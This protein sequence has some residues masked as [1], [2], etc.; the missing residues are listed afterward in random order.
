MHNRKTILYVLL[1]VCSSLLPAQEKCVSITIDDLPVAASSSATRQERERITKSLHVALLRHHAP[2]I[3]FVISGKLVRDHGLDSEQVHLLK[4]WIENGF[5]LGNHTFS[6]Q[7]YNSVTFAEF[8]EDIEKGEEV[9]E[10]AIP[11]RE[12]AVN[13]FR[14]PY[15][16]MG[17]T[18]AKA[19]S[20]HDYVVRSGY[21]EAPVTIDNADWIFSKAF[22][23]AAAQNE[24]DLM[25]RIGA[26]YLAYMEEKL[27]FYE[28]Q[29]Q[30][31]FARSIPHILLIHANAINADY[32]DE[33]LS[34]YEKHGYRFVT[35]GTALADSVYKTPVTRFGGWGISWL[36]R[37]ALSAGHTGSFFAGDPRTPPF[38]MKIA[39]VKDE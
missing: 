2:A 12:H 26:A 31:L 5:D 28:R 37:W 24:A 11:R 1:V 36:D 14:Q 30:K 19:D 23:R 25:K 3:G 33:L 34:L 13:Y 6:H 16:H 29:T 9:L 27:L 15:L 20:L 35:L 32:L 4:E 21:V 22:V 38:I 17:P 8:Q 10:W 39:D 7:D 18:K